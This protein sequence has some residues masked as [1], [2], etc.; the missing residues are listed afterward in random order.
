MQMRLKDV[1]PAQ[2]LRWVRRGFAVYLRHPLVYTAMFAGFLFAALLLTLIPLVGPIV[3]LASLPMLTLGFMIA[4]HGA[5]QGRPPRMAA[6]VAPLRTGTPRR[7]AL[8]QLG[9]GYA[10]ATLAIVTLSDWADGGKFEALQQLLASGNVD[11]REVA[12]LLDDGQLQFGLALRFG[13]AA[14]LA[15]PY[16]HAPALVHWGGQ[17]AGQA[18]FSSMLACWRARWAFV[19]YVLAWAAVIGAFGLLVNLVFGAFGAPQLVGAAAL[20]GALLLST[21]FYASLFFS[22]ADSFSASAG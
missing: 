22:F 18:L 20:P 6:F 19:A 10:L 3:L 21:A 1:R 16:W 9:L 8:L 4:T 13:L 11:A 12:A 15:L 14:L 5:T 7:R 17:G 2:G